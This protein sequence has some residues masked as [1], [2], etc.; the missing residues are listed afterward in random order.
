[1]PASS[2]IRWFDTLGLDDVPQVGGK[3][4][5]LAELHRLLADGPVTAPD[6]FA[7]T[8]AAYREA[9]TAAGAWQPLRD[10]LEDLDVRD[11]SALARAAAAARALVH[12]ATGEAGLRT[13]IVTAYRRLST[14]NGG[15]L[16]VAVR[17]SATAEDLPTATISASPCRWR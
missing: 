11:V 14:Q 9:L 1:M 15:R 6:G 16:S 12:E 7:V 8:A 5:S 3:T 4:A 10:L 17:S 13:A 2:R